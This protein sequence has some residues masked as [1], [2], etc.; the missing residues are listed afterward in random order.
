MDDHTLKT[1]SS[2]TGTDGA[3]PV[4]EADLHAYADQLL[5][6]ERIA[7]VEKFLATHPA[8]QARVHDWQQQNR[9]LHNFLD[10]VMDEPLPLRL[11]LKATAKRFP[12]SA[13]AACVVVGIMSGGSAW[14]LRGHV[15]AQAL[16]LA[17]A[18]APNAAPIMMSDD[19]R[20]SGFAQRAAVA[21][22]VYSPDVRRPVE[23][24]ANQEQALVT[25]LTK[26]MGTE[27]KAPSLSHVGYELIGGRLLPG[28][29]GPVAQFMYVSESEQRLTL[30]VT[31]E[32][33][34]EA[35][36]AFQFGNDGPINV[37][38]WVENNFG[39]A[40][41]AGADRAELMRVSQAVYAQMNTPTSSLF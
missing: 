30:Y 28:E 26:R 22:V 6:P 40:I 11:P 7:H 20:L 23:V 3:K 25:W 39:Y 37:F 2:D 31:R 14:F 16:Q 8:E 33:P 17:L 15:D 29:R 24:S 5:P 34:S 19:G 13:L 18:E 12:W 36:T 9:M 32:I 1:L 27:V 35:N 38:Y 4:T 41:S 21:H 10:P